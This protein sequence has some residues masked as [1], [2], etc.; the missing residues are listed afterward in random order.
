MHDEFRCIEDTQKKGHKSSCIVPCTCHFT[1]TL[2]YLLNEI[3]FRFFLK[4]KEVI[5][6]HYLIIRGVL[7]FE[8]QNEQMSWM[9]F[10]GRTVLF[11][12]HQVSTEK[13]NTSSV[14]KQTCLI[15][16]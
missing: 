13:T 16:S 11:D 4:I 10:A 1:F 9:I 15:F 12:H 7:E 3:L 8:E 2:D 14:G 6:S 5:R